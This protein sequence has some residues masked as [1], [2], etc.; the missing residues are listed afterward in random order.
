MM[1]RHNVETSWRSFTGEIWARV[2]PPLAEGEGLRIWARANA[3]CFVQET[4]H[5]TYVVPSTTPGPPSIGSDLCRGTKRIEISGLVP[6]AEVRIMRVFSDDVL[7]AFMAAHPVQ[8]VDLAGL[9]VVTGDQI[10]V[11]QGLCGVFSKPSPVPAHVLLPADHIDPVF[12]APPV[13]CARALEL[14]GLTAG[15]TVQIFSTL[16]GG[17]IGVANAADDRVVVYVSPPLLDGDTLTVVVDGCASATMQAAVVQQAVHG[18]VITRAVEGEIGVRIV[19]VTAGSTVDIKDRK[20]T[21]ASAVVTRRE[22]TIALAAPLER[23]VLHAHARL[24]DRAADGPSVDVTP[25][26]IP[27]F[28]RVSD[29]ART[30]TASGSRGGCRRFCRSLA[31]RSS[32][33]RKRLDCGCCRRRRRPARRQR[34]RCRCPGSIRMC[35]A[36]PLESGRRMSMSARAMVFGKRT[37]P[38]PIR[39][40]RGRNCPVCPPSTASS[41]SPAAT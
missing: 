34:N 6:S 22:A 7:L 19:D 38:P 37:R 21:L 26:H 13:A 11:R 39:C 2:E 23:T 33:E 25:W 8:S 15:S 29:G 4:G 24:C 14:A 31:A 35:T 40:A 10:T 3:P 9:D 32:R 20:W 30:R 12:A 17:L 41:W 18:P 1:E 27:A 16:L 5:L 28:S 36:S